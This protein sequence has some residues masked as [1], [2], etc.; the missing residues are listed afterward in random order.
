[1]HQL[2]RDRGAVAV[3]LA[4]DRPQRRQVGV[5]GAADL[6]GIEGADRVPDRHRPH[7]DQTDAS[8]CPCSEPR[9]RVL[10]GQVD[11]HGAHRQPVPQLECPDRAGREQVFE[12]H[13]AIVERVLLPGAG[14]CVDLPSV[15]P[16]TDP[17]IPRSD[18]VARSDGAPSASAFD[19]SLDRLRR[20]R[21]VKWSL[22]GPDVLAAWVAE[23]DFDVA[24]PVRC[25]VARGRGPGRPGLRRGRS[26]GADHRLRGVPLAT[27]RLGSSADTD[28]PGGGRPDRDRRRAGRVRPR[29]CR[30]GRSHSGVSAVLRDR[31]ARWSIGRC[32]S[33]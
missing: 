10:A 9:H 24:E 16:M 13:A 30:S 23:M 7:D 18:E 20:R 27:V 31:R 4:G 29:R 32:P 22:Y 19:V 17:D 15:S 12:G 1:M 2:R 26:V 28:L 8:P 14:T 11:P 21:T 5:G 25:R 3:D 6:T 33:R